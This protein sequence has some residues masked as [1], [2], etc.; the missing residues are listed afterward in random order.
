MLLN[1]TRKDLRNAGDNYPVWVKERYLQVPDSVKAEVSRLAAQ[2]TSNQATTFDKVE[3]VTNYLR[4]NMTYSETIPSPPP[5]TDPVNWFLFNWKSGFCN[6]Y[7]SSEVLLLRSANIPARIV[8]GFAQGKADASGTYSVRG[9][10]AHAWPEVYFPGIGWVEF[11]PTVN[12]LPIVRPSGDTPATAGIDPRSIANL[13]SSRA[14]R[15]AENPETRS[16][17]RKVIFWGLTQEQWLW[18]IISVVAI[19]VVGFST[20]QLER[21]KPFIQKVPRAVKEVYARYN[22][23]SPVWVDRWVRWSEVSTI[24]R[25]FHAINQCLSWM[26][27]PQPNHATPAE[28]AG[29]LKSLVPD[30]EQDI[31][32]LAAAL[33]QSLYTLHPADTTNAIRAGWRIRIV[34]LRKIMLH[35]WNGE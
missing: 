25:A 11:E 13:N 34:T 9:Q 33:E 4:Q 20:W 21:R 18:I 12:Q 32:Y 5:G 1:P 22:I 10:D 19:V 2:I 7:A 24:E 17:T 35:R 16:T 8:V 31:E 15:E 26:H 29:L 28:R 27:K 30:A 23:K 3:A 6:Y 14:Q